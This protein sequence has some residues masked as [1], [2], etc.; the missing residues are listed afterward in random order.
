AIAAK[1]EERRQI[2]VGALNALQRQI[3]SKEESRALLRDKEKKAIQ[4]ETAARERLQRVSDD[5]R[6]AEARWRERHE[7]LERFVAV[8]P[9]AAEQGAARYM[10]ATRNRANAAIVQNYTYNRQ[11]LLTQAER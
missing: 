6:Q 11:G 1:E 10:E 5:L 2:D 7:E 9:A 8:H 3:A 4:D